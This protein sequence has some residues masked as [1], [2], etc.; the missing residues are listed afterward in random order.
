MNYLTYPM[1]T[2]RIT[3]NYKG[4]T[5]HYPHTV[6]TPKDYPIDE[7]GKD[8]GR[9]G[10]YCPCDEVKIVRVYGVG[11]GGTN[12]L[13]IESTQKV[14]FADGTCD[15]ACG[16]ITHPNDTDIKNLYVGRKFKRGDLICKEG[17]DGATANHLHISFGKGKFKG[18]GWKKNTRSK[19]VLDCTG[20]ACKP[21]SLF[22]IDPDF[23]EVMSKGDIDFKNLPEDYAVGTY[24]VNTAVLNVRK[25]AGTNFAKVG[26]LVKGRKIKV[27][28]TDGIWG[29][30]ADKKWVCLEYCKKEQVI[31]K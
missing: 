8:T 24:K 20:G 13:W 1:K 16:L 18:N 21:E 26:T 10:F 6:G 12:T 2:M 9:D 3:Q 31:K 25:G 11:S 7:G 14:H 22:Y 17:T 27:V 30:I 23:T 28:E 29:R 4:K 5:S 19:Y 15:Y